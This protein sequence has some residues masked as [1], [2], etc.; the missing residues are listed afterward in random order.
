MSDWLAVVLTLGPALAIVGAIGLWVRWTEAR[1]DR[2]TEADRLARERLAEQLA[3][4][5]DADRAWLAEMGW[6][7][8]A[9]A[10]WIGTESVRRSGREPLNLR[11]SQIDWSRR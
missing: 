7:P 1:A 6:R 9:W 8:P 2:K 10:T 11:P 3:A 4:L 5:T